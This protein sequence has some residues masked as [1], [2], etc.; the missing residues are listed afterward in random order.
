MYIKSF[1]TETFEMLQISTRDGFWTAIKP[2]FYINSEHIVNSKQILVWS[3]VNLD[4]RWASNDI[5][6][7]I[8]LLQIA[9]R[10]T[11]QHGPH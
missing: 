7:R 1:K 4:F 6:E 3:Y 8:D 2:K 11:N 5:L 9:S 10:R